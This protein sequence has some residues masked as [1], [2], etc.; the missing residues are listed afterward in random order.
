[1]IKNLFKHQI[2]VYVCTHLRS[3]SGRYA[4][5]KGSKRE[6]AHIRSES[7]SSSRSPLKR[8]RQI[9]INN[10]LCGHKAHSKFVMVILETARSQIRCGLIRE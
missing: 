5:D 7:R 10:S 2:Y 1:M 9:E 4:N 6:D 8:T 3:V